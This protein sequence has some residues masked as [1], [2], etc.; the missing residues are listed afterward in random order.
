M[1]RLPPIL[2]PRLTVRYLFFSALAIYVFYCFHFASP[3]LAS[4]LPEHNG[5]F[6]VGTIDVEAPCQ[7]RAISPFKLKG[8]GGPGLPLDTVLFSMYY[9]T[10]DIR[11]RKPDH[12]WVPKPISVTAEGYLRFGH[13]NNFITNGIVTAALWSLAGGITIPAAVDVPLDKQ[14]EKGLNVDW[15][16]TDGFPV[17]IFSHGFA[18][19]RTDY[20]HYLGELARRGYVVAAIE[21]RDGSSP[22]S[23]V[24]RNGSTDRVALPIRL[25]DLEDHPDLNASS[26]KRAQLNFREAEV[27][28]TLRV[29][30]LINDGKGAEI[31]KQNPRNEGQDL[32]MW[33]D[34]L[35][36]NEITMAGHSF[37]ATLAVCTPFRCLKHNANL[38]RSS[39]RSNRQ[40]TSPFAAASPSI[41][42]LSFPPSQ[43]PI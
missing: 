4:N 24:M 37:G 14:L 18:S 15:K 29:L 20:T 11:N 7:R 6:D 19:S 30:Q 34:R 2:Y 1:L 32:A 3:L 9:P 33:E 38:Y 27:Q 8:S 42:E 31:Y 16:T 41:R 43:R 23:V 36:M 10:E 22:G 39:K 25:S 40:P 28:E 13:V 26:F 5:P 35:N 17:L 21:H 12:Y